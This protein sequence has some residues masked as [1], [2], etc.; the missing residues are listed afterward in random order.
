[1]QEM[2]IVDR[3][4]FP[5]G[6]AASHQTSPR[7]RQASRADRHVSPWGIEQGTQIAMLK[8][9]MIGSLGQC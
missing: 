1:M 6:Q 4:T 7:S 8:I 2:T 5:G 9:L 3:K